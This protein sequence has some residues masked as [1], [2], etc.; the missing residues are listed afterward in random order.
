MINKNF[1]KKPSI[2][3]IIAVVLFAG[4]WFYNYSTSK[5]E[6][7]K[8]IR[9]VSLGTTSSGFWW[10]DM[11]FESREEAVKGCLIDDGEAEQR[12]KED[13]ER[14]EKEKEVFYERIRERKK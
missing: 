1:F 4:V 5:N 6:C 8:Q 10:R 3:I 14:F 7:R 11:K 2:L 9:Y 13:T 12:Q